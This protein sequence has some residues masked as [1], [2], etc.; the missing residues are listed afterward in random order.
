LVVALVPAGF[1]L[2]RGSVAPSCGDARPR[3][4]GVWEEERKGAVR[5][6]FLATNLPFA[7][8][9][10]Q[11]VGG[12][13]DDYAARWVGMADEAC[14]AT[15]VEGRQSDQLL[16]LRM[17]CL[18]RRRTTLGA[19]T[20][21]W[22]RG[23]DVEA[24]DNAIRAAAVLPSLDEC[25]DTRALTERVPPPKDAAARA[26]IDALH[27]ELDRARAL[28]QAKHMQEA[29]KAAE[30]AR[31][32]A[33][34][35]GYAPAQAEAAFLLG[36][37]IQDF[38]EPGAVEPLADAMRFAELAR[39]DSLAAEAAVKLTGA[40]AVGG[41]A[42]SAIQ[43]ALVAEALV[44]RAGDRPQ[45]RGAL[46]HWRGTALSDVGRYGEAVTVLT[47]ART[48]LTRAVGAND[49]LTLDTGTEL[50]RALEGRG[51]V[52]PAA[53]LK[54]A[55][56]NFAAT[57][58]TLGANHPETGVALGEL[59]KHTKLWGD[60]AASRPL[61]ERSIA[62]AESAFGPWSLRTAFAVNILGNL[63]QEQGHV[64]EAQRQFERVLAIRQKLLAPD[65]PLVAHALANLSQITRLEGRLDESL[66]QAST[67]LAIMQRNYGPVH[68]DVGYEHAVVADA[69]LSKGDI[70]G[71]REHYQ[72]ALDT[73]TKIVGPTGRH[74]LW[75]AVALASVDARLGRC[76]DTRRLLAPLLAAMEAS[77]SGKPFP[78]ALLTM[79]QCDLQRGAPVEAVRR[80]ERALALFDPISAARAS[81]GLLALRGRVRFELAR[82]LIAAKSDRAR[83]LALARE[84][85]QDLVHASPFA[86]GDLGR[87]RGWLGRFGSSTR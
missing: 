36:S 34:A 24:L 63:E 60:T 71:A 82:A 80:L 70:D 15:R 81:G 64:S 25:A 72:L 43:L 18:E 56:E 52:V 38:G 23:V 69:L 1:L 62:I 73:Y 30:E 28:G 39:D 50:L 20:A 14:R 66:T 9:T 19:L 13:L 46:L 27:A 74:A 7:E 2:R 47:E 49:P 84:A 51:D 41:L 3:L 87:V 35:T 55:E 61:I 21:E 4:A 68:P 59:G 57:R 10:W 37:L 83:A 22:S 76:A 86:G 12:R 32:H 77:P 31:A 54:I 26:R 53:M 33:D 75:P 48:V 85:E 78:D 58:D 17:A 79:A 8:E 6:A 11:R 65:N 44:L 16:D 67:A 42:P 40:M 29:R 45:L 5:A